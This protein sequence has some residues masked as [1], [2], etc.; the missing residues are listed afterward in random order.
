MRARALTGASPFG[1]RSTPDARPLA[2]IRQ[3]VW[4][5]WIEAEQGAADPGL[6]LPS[7]KRLAVSFGVAAARLLPGQRLWSD[8]DPAGVTRQAGDQ[9]VCG[10]EVRGFE[11]LASS[12][13]E[14]TG[15]VA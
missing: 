2:I 3:N 14:R 9:G 7:D 10:V 6:A 1:L 5:D 11:P 4:L 15:V 13:R 12:V 8:A